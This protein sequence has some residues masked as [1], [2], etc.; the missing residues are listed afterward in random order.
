M[1]RILSKQIFPRVRRVLVSSLFVAGTASPLRRRVWWMVRGHVVL[2]ASVSVFLSLMP[3]MSTSV[4]FAQQQPR[5]TVLSDQARPA[6][7]DLLRVPGANW[8]PGLLKLGNRSTLALGYQDDGY[9]WN[10][11]GA[12]VALV[13]NELLDPV[14]GAPA[15]NVIIE[16]DAGK[17]SGGDDNGFGVACRANADGGAYLLWAGTDGT[18]SITRTIPN[19]TGHFDLHQLADGTMPPAQGYHL[20][21]EC[22]DSHLSL[23]V[24]GTKVVE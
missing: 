20:R 16:V 11:D 2:A 6:V 15:S 23:S 13:V 19:G 7:N 18:A 22:I 12:G 4:S 17:S 9:H 24:N 5:V 14:V 3:G 10:F 21:A 8:R 1:E